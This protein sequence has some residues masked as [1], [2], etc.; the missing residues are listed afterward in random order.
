L[1]ARTDQNFAALDAW[2]EAS[3]WAAW[4]AQDPATR[5]PTSMCLSI[6][7]PTFLSLD[8]EKRQALIKTMTGWLDDEAVA[9]D[10]GN[11]RDAP[12]GFRIWGGATV[13][14][15]DI[16]DLTPW[17]DWAFENAMQSIQSTQETTA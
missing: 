10:I 16:T 11:Y 4:L 13:D 5:S 7:D 9:F 8:I 1:K 3:D 12:P 2:V 17:L 15:S 14:A 6:V